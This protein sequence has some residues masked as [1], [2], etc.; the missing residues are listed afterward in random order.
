MSEAVAVDRPDLTWIILLWNMGRIYIFSRWTNYTILPLQIGCIADAKFTH[1]GTRLLKWGWSL[2]AIF[3]TRNSLYPLHVYW[4]IEY[5]KLNIENQGFG[6]TPRLFAFAWRMI[7]CILWPIAP[8]L[9]CQLNLKV[10]HLVK[11]LRSGDRE[12][13]YYKIER[14]GEIWISIYSQIT[15]SDCLQDYVR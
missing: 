12:S 7:S 14:G 10:F 3:V 11:L 5:P 1:L 6:V 13:A 4:Y 2:I 9:P 15:M 8:P